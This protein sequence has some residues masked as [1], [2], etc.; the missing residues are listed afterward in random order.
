MQAK[1]LILDERGPDQEIFFGDE[2]AAEAREDERLRVGAVVTLRL[3]GM[4]LDVEVLDHE[5][6][7]VWTGTLRGWEGHA[8]QPMKGLRVGDVLRFR[9]E[10]VFALYHD[11]P[12]ASRTP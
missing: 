7:G 4:P 1:E 3:H 6:D 11:A 8:G 12:A 9:E 2:A 10:Q 5:E